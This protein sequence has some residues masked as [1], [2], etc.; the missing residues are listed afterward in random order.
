MAELWNSLEKRMNDGL[1][2]SNPW[3][4]L[5]Q[6]VLGLGDDQPS[7]PRLPFTHGDDD[8]YVES[9]LGAALPATALVPC[10]LKRPSGP[11]GGLSLDIVTQGRTASPSI[12]LQ[13]HRHD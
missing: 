7:W 6:L 4:H 3:R 2:S 11:K 10:L 12:T 13:T 8:L 1:L 9:N 5:D